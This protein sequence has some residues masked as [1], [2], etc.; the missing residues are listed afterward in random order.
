MLTF[1]GLRRRRKQS[2]EDGRAKPTMQVEESEP[3]LANIT[4]RKLR[5]MVG[6]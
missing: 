3:M 4:V 5:L 2:T 6:Q 1:T